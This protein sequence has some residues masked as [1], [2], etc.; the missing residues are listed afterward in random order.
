MFVS[1]PEQGLPRQLMPATETWSGKTYEVRGQSGNQR[2][3]TR[4]ISR[5]Y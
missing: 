1:L 5:K 2:V 3:E 4:L